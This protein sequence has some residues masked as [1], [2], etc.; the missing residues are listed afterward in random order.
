M[1]PAPI[2]VRV[3]PFGLMKMAR[4]LYFI[5]F[6]AGLMGIAVVFFSRNI[7]FDLLRQVIGDLRPNQDAA[8]LD[9][10]ATVMLWGCLGALVMVI[11]VEAILLSVMTRRHGAARWVMLIFLFVHAAVAIIAAGLLALGDAGIYVVLL[12]ATQL[13]LV[14]AALMVSALPGAR[15]WFLAENETRVHP[16]L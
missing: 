9:T 8:T 11:V 15:T 6:I 5:S 2:D 1:T 14:I 16:A 4:F 13:L 3:R 12:L 10:A 7:Q